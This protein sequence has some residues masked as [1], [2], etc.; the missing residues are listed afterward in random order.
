MKKIVVVTSYFPNSCDPQRAVFVKNLVEEIK[1]KCEVMVVSPIPFVPPMRARKDWLCLARIERREIIDHIEVSHPRYLVIPKLELFSGVSYMVG[2]VR[3]LWK[4]KQENRSRMV[5]H[6]HCAYPDGM[7]VAIAAKILGI[8][9]VITAHGSDINVLARTR[10]LRW[11]IRWAL[12]NAAAVIGV[13]SAICTKI[14]ELA[15]RPLDRL[16]HIPCAGYDPRWFFPKDRLQARRNV[17]QMHVDR[18]VLFIGNLV[19]IKGAEVLICAWSRLQKEGMLSPNDKLAIIGDGPLRNPLG[20]QAKESCQIGTV[21]FAGSVPHVAIAD[22][23]NA[24][25]LLC[26]PSYNEGTPNVIIES[27]ACGIPVVSTNVG[28]IPDVVQEEKNGLLVEPGDVEKFAE[29]LK[30]GLNMEWQ[31]KKLEESVTGYTWKNLAE[32]NLKVLGEVVHGRSHAPIC[33]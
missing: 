23:I 9:Y 25:N 14:S 7:G 3:H 27:L 2:I 10:T 22:W 24:A 17:G 32:R 33:P 29:A 18:L 28:G 5:I 13:S 30:A 11:Q 26:L 15:G 20:E 19:K 12:R 6:A 31:E 4:L 8:S 16:V 1:K 21:I